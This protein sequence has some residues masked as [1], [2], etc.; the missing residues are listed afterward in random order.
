MVV[1]AIEKIKAGEVGGISSG[2]SWGGEFAIL[3][4]EASLTGDI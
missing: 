3:D 4:N 1:G 2:P